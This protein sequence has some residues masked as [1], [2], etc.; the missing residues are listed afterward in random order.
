M[1]DEGFYNLGL[2]PMEC[3]DIQTSKHATTVYLNYPIEALQKMEF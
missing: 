1:I 3:F 2:D